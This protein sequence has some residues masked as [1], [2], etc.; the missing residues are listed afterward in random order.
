M[1]SLKSFFKNLSDDKEHALKSEMWIKYRYLLY[2]RRWGPFLRKASRKT[3][4]PRQPTCTE[5][6]GGKL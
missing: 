1:V 6:S 2:T 5:V 3:D 4:K